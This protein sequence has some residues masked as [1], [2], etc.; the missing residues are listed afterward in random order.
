MAK[1]GAVFFLGSALAASAQTAAA[2]AGPFSGPFSC[3]L[4]E[5]QAFLE[6][7]QTFSGYRWIECRILSAEPLQIDA[8]T[9]N[10]GNCAASDWFSGRTFTP[11]DTLYI[12]YACMSPVRLDIEVGGVALRVPL[13]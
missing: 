4:R 7:L 3:R 10:G 13:R 5:T 2:G 8:V 12:P 6:D 11:G 1:L 9:I